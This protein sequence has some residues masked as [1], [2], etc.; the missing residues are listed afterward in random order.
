MGCFLT[1]REGPK[2][3]AVGFDTYDQ[4]LELLGLVMSITASAACPGGGK[5]LFWNFGREIG[6]KGWFESLSILT[7]TIGAF[8]ESF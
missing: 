3:V 6:I 5:C 7:G 4:E 2:F 1:D 8:F